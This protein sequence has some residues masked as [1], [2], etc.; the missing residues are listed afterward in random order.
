MEKTLD[1]LE[2]MNFDKEKTIKRLIEAKKAYYTS[3]QAI[4]SDQEYD[5]LEELLKQHDPDHPFFETVGHPPSDLWT[6]APHK[7]KMGSLNKC[8]SEEEFLKW[9]SKY[10]NEKFILQPKLD[11]LSLS[12]EY[13]NSLFIRAITRGDGLEGEEI[14]D[15]VQLMKNFQEKLFLMAE[16]FTGA[17]RCEILM[18][19]NDFDQINSIL[20]EED[21]YSNPRNAA[22]GISRKLDGKFCRYLE[23]IAY[24]ITESLDKTKKL[25][26]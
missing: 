6:S 1:A 15:N 12:L 18:S 19:K 20:P 10:P 21:K 3:G 11:G 17:I 7:I 13:E 2:E 5:A 9:T 23:L 25:K 14:S 8:N 16:P 26:G 22:S 4:I 24:D